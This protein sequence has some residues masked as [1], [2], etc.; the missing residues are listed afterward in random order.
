MYG[1][2][3]FTGTL[4]LFELCTFFTFTLEL[5][6]RTFFSGTLGGACGATPCIRSDPPQCSVHSVDSTIK[7]QRRGRILPYIAVGE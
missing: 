4:T 6:I 7:Q 3:F 5:R 2:S 1:S